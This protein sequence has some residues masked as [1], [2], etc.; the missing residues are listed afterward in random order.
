M[1]IQ[2]ACSRL[3]S[4]LKKIFLNPSEDDLAGI[5]RGAS[6][7]N[8]RIPLL[9]MVAQEKVTSFSSDQQVI[10]NSNK[11]SLKDFKIIKN[12]GKGAFGK[13]YLVF[14]SNMEKYFA[15]KTLKKEFIKK[16]KQIIHTKT[17]REILEKIDN[18]FIAKLFFAFHN[19]ENLF[20]ITEYM[21]GGE[22]FYH[23]VK[24]KYFSE[25]RTKFYLCEI[26]LALGH[27]HSR[28]IIYRDLKPE[29]IL[30]DDEGHIK[31]TD[32]GLSKILIDKSKKTYTICGTPGYVAPEVLVGKGYDKSVDW[33]SLGVI[34]YEMLTG[35]APFRE[36]SR[37]FDLSVYYSPVFRTK[38]LS[39]EAYD[40]IQKLLNINPKKRLGSGINDYKDIQKHIF[41]KDVNWDMIYRKEIKPEFV[42]TVTHPGDVSYC[43]QSLM[44]ESLSYN[45]YLIGK[46][47]KIKSTFEDFTFVNSNIK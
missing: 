45:K 8:K 27:L 20:I 1:L 39:D 26:I 43:D 14:N 25:Q 31:L 44:N 5:N 10:S 47:Q 28:H 46:T 37:M 24:E 2:K 23:I 6:E 22:L 34:V 29:N 15:M 18:P 32:F 41:F 16:R 40:L 42:P 17:E 21:P 36:A 35:C 13:V 38:N 9:D 12:L 11:V 4:C 30:L 19:K 7:Q 3:T 33:W